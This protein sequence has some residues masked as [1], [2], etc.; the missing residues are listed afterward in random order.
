MIVVLV[1]AVPALAR[2]GARTESLLCLLLAGASLGRY[3]ERRCKAA[4][5]VCEYLIAFEAAGLERARAA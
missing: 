1:L 3:A 4:E 5:R 2:K